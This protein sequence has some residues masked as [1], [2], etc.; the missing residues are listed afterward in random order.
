MA[1]NH[2]GVIGVGTV[3]AKLLQFLPLLFWGG[4]LKQPH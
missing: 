2:V 4:S 1:C 3:G